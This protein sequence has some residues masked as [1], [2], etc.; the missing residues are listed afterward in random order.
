M[1]CNVNTFNIK[2][3][4]IVFCKKIENNKRV[5]LFYYLEL[6]L[7]IYISPKAKY[8][9]PKKLKLTK[10]QRFLV[11]YHFVANLMIYLNIFK[12]FL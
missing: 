9:F 3:I 8:R 2:L 12:I 11:S 10:N 1:Y 6:F 7:I 5:K 4:F